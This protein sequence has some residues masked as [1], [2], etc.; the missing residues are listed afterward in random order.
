MKTPLALMVAALSA[1]APSASDVSSQPVPPGATAPIPGVSERAMRVYRE[2]IVI[3]AHN[4]IFTNVLDEGYDPDVR[5]PAGVSWLTPGAGQSDLPRFIESGITGQWLSAFIDAPYAR[6]TPDG[7]YERTIVFLDTIDAWLARHPD[8]LIRAT[9]AADV[10]RAKQQGRIAMLVGVEGGHA[11]EN[12]LDNLREI[13]RRGARY[14]TLTWN[15]GTDWA[16]S[17]GGIDGTRTGGLTD[18]G[19]DVVREMNRLGMLVDV[20]H[21]SEETFFD[22][23]ETSSDP[24]IASHSSARAITDHVRNL[25]DDQL[26]AIARNGGVV[27]VNFFP[28]FIDPAHWAAFR[29][30]DPA[31][32]ALRDSLQRSGATEAS[33]NARV[34]L[35]RSELTRAI[36]A[37]PLSVLIDH[38]DHIAKVAGV[39]HVGIGSDFDGISS[40]PE[41]MEDVTRLPRIADAL[42]ERGYSEDDVKRILGGNMLRVMEQVIDR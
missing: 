19:R 3:D 35:R 2:A 25:T 30:I 22:A 41:G 36:P 31:L 13:H 12:S 21:V 20:S 42:L 32:D 33:V 16:G 14:L 23:I 5:H 39:N 28:R 37:T 6:Q 17:S 10:R 24:I 26:R 9:T 15:N 29:A 11:I 27:N 18:F 7:S 1:C 34:A 8:R 4:D 40:A 38:F